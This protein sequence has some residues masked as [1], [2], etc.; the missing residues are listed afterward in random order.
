MRTL[1]PNLR[2]TS[3]CTTRTWSSA[4]ASSSAMAAVL[5]V[6]ASSMM[7]ISY[8]PICPVARRSDA[9]SRAASTVRW[10]ISS[11][12]HIG[13]MKVRLPKVGSMAALKVVERPS[14]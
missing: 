7:R 11:S 1:A 9:V 14:R 8:S 5:S 4:A 12:F 10:I 3:W 2:F 13:N 6:D